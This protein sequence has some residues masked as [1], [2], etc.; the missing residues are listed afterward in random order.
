MAKRGRGSLDLH[1]ERRPSKPWYGPPARR[2]TRTGWPGEQ[3]PGPVQVRRRAKPG[4]PR[5][6][7]ALWT[8]ERRRR[9][10]SRMAKGGRGPLDLHQRKEANALAGMAHQQRRQGGHK[11]QQAHSKQ[12]EGTVKI[13]EGKSTEQTRTTVKVS[14]KNT[15]RRK[16]NQSREKQ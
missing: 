16:T 3:E 13:R 9:K 14:K 7:G 4:W 8:W 10:E 1:T 2:E 6:A 12:V 11:W 5:V 15:E